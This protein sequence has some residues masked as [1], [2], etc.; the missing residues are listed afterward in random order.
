MIELG[1]RFRAM[2]ERGAMG[3]VLNF[4]SSPMRIFGMDRVA[5]SQ[6][7]LGRS[8]RVVSADGVVTPF[9]TR[10]YVPHDVC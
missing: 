1:A 3:L 6:E 5:A 9:A 2:L 7:V 8:T 4:D 10:P